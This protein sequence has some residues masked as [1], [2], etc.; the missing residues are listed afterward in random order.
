[1][2]QNLLTQKDL[3]YQQAQLQIQNAVDQAVKELERAEADAQG[4][5]QTQRNQIAADEMRGMDNAALYAEMRGDR[6]GIGMS[7]FNAV[8]AAAA[9]NR[10]AVSQQQ[11]K[12]ATDTARQ[13]SD[14]RAQGEF[15]KADKLLTITQNYLSQLLQLE[16]WANEFNLSIDQLN[17]SIRQ[18]QLG[19]DLSVREL[20]LSAQQWQAEFNASQQ[21][22]QN[23]NLAASGEALLAAGVLPNASQLAAMGMTSSQASAYMAAAKAAQAAASAKGNGAGGGGGN[24]VTAALGSDAWYQQVSD[25]AAANGQSVENFLDANGKALGLTT[26]DLRDKYLGKYED[27]LDNQPKIL[28]TQDMRNLKTDLS[29]LLSRG[30]QATAVDMVEDLD[31]KGRLTDEQYNELVY[32]INDHYGTNIG[33]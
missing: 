23:Q 7:Q 27:W 28:S 16:Q 32:I 10:L 15:E 21:A 18:W 33:I 3:A 29:V 12:L 4:Q 26:E 8:Q 14:L 11:T 31:A 19:Y 6:G 2:Q 30:Q 20:N 22:A 9:Q 17:E 5:F 25:L 13:I 1:M 24:I